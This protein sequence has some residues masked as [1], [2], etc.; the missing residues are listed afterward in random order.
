MGFQYGGG[1]AVV[2]EARGKQRRLGCKD[3]DRGK[4]EEAGLQWWRQGG[5]RGGWAARMEAGGQQ[6]KLG[7]RQGENMGG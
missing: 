1:W 4:I 3:G 5:N 7:W 2:S 6:K